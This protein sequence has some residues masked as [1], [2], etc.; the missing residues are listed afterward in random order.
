MEVSK[1]TIDSLLKHLIASGRYLA[2]KDA[3]Y[4]ADDAVM[5]YI[6]GK[7]NLCAVD[8]LHQFSVSAARDVDL[9]EQIV[10]EEK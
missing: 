2:A 8:E 7:A 10:E 1:K 5:R 3:G 6:G 9:V 4:E